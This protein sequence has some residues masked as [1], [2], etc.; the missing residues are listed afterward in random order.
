MKDS[1]YTEA[2]ERYAALEIDTEHALE[3]L[4]TIP[5]SLH[6]WQTD[7]VGGFESP[8]AVLS[9]GG[10]QVTGNF[11]GK[12]RN[13][14]EMRRDLDEVY[15]LIPGTHRLALH[16]SY[17]E[18]GNT[19]V[20]RDAIGPEHFYGWADWAADRE[21]GIDFNGT[22][23]SHPKADDGYTLSHPDSAIRSFWIEHGIMSREVSAMFG[24]KLN[25]PCI[26]N[27]WIPDGAKDLPVDR[28]GYRRR[29]MESLDLM[30]EKNIRNR[31]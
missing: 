8:G 20:D 18:F 4:K 28:L 29:L 24:R 26:C 16:M 21:L 9:G 12:S 31:K 2:V 11:P 1:L 10:I 17:G 6:C 3:S 27:T 22:Y 14:D 19:F 25:N 23:F 13:I 5:L 7:D 30:M 15:S